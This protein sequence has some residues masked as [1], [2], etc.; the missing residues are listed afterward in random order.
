MNNLYVFFSLTTYISYSGTQT[1][2]EKKK[3]KSKNEDYR[4]DLQSK[5]DSDQD[6]DSETVIG[7]AP[8]KKKK[9]FFLLCD[10]FAKSSAR[11]EKWIQCAECLPCGPT[12]SA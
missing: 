5:A 2:T 11:D 6:G 7:K 1:D 12:L 3:N 4:S 9:T 8:H 10:G